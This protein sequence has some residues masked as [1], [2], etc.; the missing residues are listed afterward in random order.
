MKP[1]GVQRGIVGEVIKR[2]E[3]K[4]YKL[5]GLKMV[6]PSKEKA[7]GHYADLSKKGFFG[8]LT[9][10]FSSGPI[11]AM[12]WEGED[13]IATGRRMLGATKV[14]TQQRQRTPQREGSRVRMGG[15][16]AVRSNSG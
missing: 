13:V 2:F 11:V 10:F 7:E 14:R 15:L 12:V 4:G 6:K 5:V 1:D 8:A 16:A 3:Q 9:D